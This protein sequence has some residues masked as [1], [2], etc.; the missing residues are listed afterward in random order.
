MYAES[1]SSVVPRT[2]IVIMI[3]ITYKNCKFRRLPRD[4]GTVPFSELLDRFLHIGR[5]YGCIDLDLNQRH[6]LSAYTAHPK[7]HA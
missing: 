3:R 1:E 4:L 6:Y 7:Y 5:V 2:T